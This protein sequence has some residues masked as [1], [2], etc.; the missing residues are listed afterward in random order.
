MVILLGILVDFCF[1]LMILSSFGWDVIHWVEQ[2]ASTDKL[3]NWF[4]HGSVPK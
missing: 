3:F 2:T 4:G 1:A